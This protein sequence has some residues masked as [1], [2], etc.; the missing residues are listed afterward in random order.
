MSDAN[1]SNRS[2]DDDVRR[3][4]RSR[5]RDGLP[6]NA[7]TLR[8]AVGGGGTQ[9][10]VRLLRE[11][12]AESHD[13]SALQITTPTATAEGLP[14]ELE[15]HFHA[16]RADMLATIAR[17]RIEE[18][19]AAAAAMDQSSR[20]AQFRVDRVTDDETTAT[21]NALEL[22]ACLDFALARVGDLEAQNTA[23]VQREAHANMLRRDEAAISHA[24]WTALDTAYHTLAARVIPPKPPRWRSTPP[25]QT[26]ASNKKSR[27][28]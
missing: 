3:I 13:G 18:R 4:I 14:P 19:A 12:R 7:P 10:L 15:K 1:A 8:D 11:V 16:L 25:R 5:L 24:R 9:R 20:A 26:G 21:N 28:A 2:T 17:V 6:C 27:K 22:A 23:L